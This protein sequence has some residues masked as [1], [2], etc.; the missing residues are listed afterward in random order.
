MERVVTLRNPSLSGRRF[1]KLA[2]GLGMDALALA[3]KTRLRVASRTMVLTTNPWIAVSLRFLGHRNL[4]SLGIFATPGS[5]TWT[6]FRRVIPHCSMIVMST[7]E[8]DNWRAEGGTAAYVRYG[9]SFPYPPP[10]S[11]PRPGST[12]RIFI[13]GSSDRDHALID[14]IA[15]EVLDSGADIHLTIAVGD[16]PTTQ[17][18][19]Q[20]EVRRL[21]TLSQEEFGEEL[22][23]AT[24][25]FLPLEQ[26][27]RS[28]GHMFIVGSLQVGTPV[29][30]TETEGMREYGD[31]L[32]CRPIPR[33][34]SPLKYLLEGAASLPS[35][36]DT[37]QF[38]R[39][40][41]SR[42]S[43]VEA[44][45]DASRAMSALKNADD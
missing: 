1:G 21:A 23:N 31:A 33:G 11:G 22:R 18:S 9:N 7:L 5:R 32:F 37:H 19:G 6:L 40:N 2:L 24:V 43:F 20:A 26:S 13:G 3:L 44:V 41:F 34:V 12:V 8:R 16:G 4:V 27:G 38:W 30:Y 29:L 35:A 15:A 45:L 10:A 28:A 17:R 25:S 39:A 36:H 14:R 42:K